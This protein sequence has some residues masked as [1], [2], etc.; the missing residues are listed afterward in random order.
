MIISRIS[1]GCSPHLTRGLRD[2]TD[3]RHVTEESPIGRAWRSKSER[4][5]EEMFQGPLKSVIMVEL[6]FDYYKRPALPLLA[7]L[8]SLPSTLEGLSIPRI[9]LRTSDHLHALIQLP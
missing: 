8:K 4:W 7:F 9:H 2:V 6:R 5:Y 3:L 1:F